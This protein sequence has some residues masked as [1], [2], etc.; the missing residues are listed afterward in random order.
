MTNINVRLSAQFAWWM[1]PAVYLVGFACWLAG[2]PP[3]LGAID[4][5]VSKALRVDVREA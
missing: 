4:W 1:V 3:N 5:L 2:Q